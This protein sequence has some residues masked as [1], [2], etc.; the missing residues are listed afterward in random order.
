MAGL[1]A[2]CEIAVPASDAL[3]LEGAEVMAATSTGL[4]VERLPAPAQPLDVAVYAFPDLTGQNEPQEEYSELSR[5]VTQ[6][7]AD[8]LTD[9]LAKAG[10]GQWF[11]VVERARVDNLL[12]ERSIIEQ[13][14]A[15]FTGGV[16]LP[17]LRFAGTLI[18]GSIVGYDTNQVT[19]GTGA[20]FLGIGSFN[21]YREDIVTIALR[22]VSVS[23]G[24]VLTSVTTTKTVY[25]V[26]VQGDAFRF[27][28]VDEILEFETGYSRNE[29]EIFATREAMELA[30]LAMIVE[31]AEEGQ[32][33]FA[34]QVAGNE[35]IE[36]YR[37][38]YELARLGYTPSQVQAMYAEAEPES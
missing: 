31:G 7:G 8:I 28:A 17:P 4:T 24:R 9:V 36:N 37:R 1:L 6:G 14:Q 16:S 3:L 23:T 27:V 10:N 29:P 30:V 38:R 18:E 25:S 11:N 22:A 26:R 33:S 15:A 32:W 20:R 35:V 13:T 12:R 2:G 21:E 34:D 5:A 19:G